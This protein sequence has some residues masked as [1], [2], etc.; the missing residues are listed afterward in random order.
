VNAVKSLTTAKYVIKAMHISNALIF[1]CPLYLQSILPFYDLDDRDI[2]DLFISSNSL[3]KEINET[4]NKHLSDESEKFFVE[5]SLYYSKNKFAN[6]L[7]NKKGITWP[8]YILIQAII[9]WIRN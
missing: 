6:L 2:E 5:D 1:T 8:L 9:Y 7:K 4:S 3:L